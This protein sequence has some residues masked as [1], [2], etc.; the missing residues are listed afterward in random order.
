MNILIRTY[1][2][3][4][5]ILLAAPAEAPCA[6][7]GTGPCSPFLDFD[8]LMDIEGLLTPIARFPL[9]PAMDM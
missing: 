3:V 5:I 6:T 9:K 8:L 7:S 1:G 4:V 2:L